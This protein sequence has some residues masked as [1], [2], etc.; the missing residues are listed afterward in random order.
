M[1]KRIRRSEQFRIRTSKRAT[2]TRKQTASSIRDTDS[3]TERLNS[4]AHMEVCVGFDV[5]DPFYDVRA[6][7]RKAHQW[8]A[9]EF[10]RLRP[11]LRRRVVVRLI[12]HR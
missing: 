1:S 12:F 11:G 3:E 4:L 2:Q 10:N 5:G 9:G 6:N 8:L 7:R